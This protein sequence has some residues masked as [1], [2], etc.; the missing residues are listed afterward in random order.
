MRSTYFRRHNT[1]QCGSVG[2]KQTPDS[3]N[4]G[5]SGM[6]RSCRLSRLE[7]IPNTGIKEEMNMEEV[8]IDRMK[9]KNLWAS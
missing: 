2:R 9:N 4:T 3:R 6:K 7:R 1:V 5:I 8:V